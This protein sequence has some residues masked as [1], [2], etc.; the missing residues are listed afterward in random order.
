MRR[1]SL[2][3]PVQLGIY[4][5][6]S[7]VLVVEQINNT[8]MISESYLYLLPLKLIIIRKLLVADAK[9]TATQSKN[10][11]LCFCYYN[12][13]HKARTSERGYRV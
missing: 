13:V 3:I 10:I 4:C 9:I 1:F 7:F 2:V 11:Y 6:S 5:Y 8:V 12:I